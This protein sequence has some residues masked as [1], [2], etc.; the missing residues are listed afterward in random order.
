METLNI[1]IEY[2]VLFLVAFL[3]V[4]IAI[5]SILCVEIYK[6]AKALIEESKKKI[7]KEELMEISLDELLESEK[8]GAIRRIIAPDAVNPGPDD[9]LI[10]YDGVRKTYCRNITISKMPKI[11]RFANTFYDLFNE[12]DS[13]YSVFV[14][15][16][17]EQDMIHKLD[18][19]ITVLDSETMQAIGDMNRQRKLQEQLRETNAW[20]MEVESGKN[21]FFRTGFVFSLYAD[22]LEALT[23]KSDLFRNAALS[24][25]LEV[26]TC[27]FVQSEAYLAN[28]PMNRYSNFTSKVN[29]TDGIFYHYMDKYAASTIFNYT[30]CTFSHKD[31]IPIGHD[32]DTGAPVI[33]N[34]Y[35]PGYNGYTHCI[36]GKTGVG[37]SAFLKLASY[38]F[39]LMDYRFASLDVQPR[40]GTGDGEY[41]GICE[42]L[43]GLNFEL[44]SDSTN[45]LNI[46]EVMP[47]T[48]Y[49]KTG[50]GTG[51]EELTLELNAAIGQ[52]ANLIQIMIAGTRNADS[53]RDDVLMTSIIKTTIKKMFASF[54]IVDGKPETLFEKGR[55]V[56]NG[57]ERNYVEKK[58]PTISDF[59][60]LLLKDQKVE[61]DP[62][63]ESMRKIILLAMEDHV[64]DLYYTEDSL[65]FFTKEEYDELPLKANT[66]IHVYQDNDNAPVEEVR[67]LHGTRP[68]FDGQSTIR[69]SKDIKWIN[70][71]CSQLDDA[72]KEE[73]MS[74]GMNYI[75]ERII[76]GNSANRG[77]SSKVAVIFDEAHMVFKMKPARKLLD[78][79]V[80][81]AR[82]RNVAL[83]ICT[84]TLAEFSQ[85]PETEGI[86][87]NAAASFIFKQDNGD[88]EFLLSKLGLT[89]KQIDSILEQGGNLDQQ[90]S[91]DTEQSVLLEKAK[92]R[93]ECTL[94]VN[95]MAVSIKIDY[96]KKTEGPVVE[97]EASE[98]I[99]KIKRVS[100]ESYI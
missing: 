60:T 41:A 78:E 58:L 75:N 91:V 2:R 34:M 48:R 24:K 87:K 31:G 92:H 23:R 62:D 57:K 85:Y 11:V 35:A 93:G 39:S 7:T 37:K 21:K 44:K 8:G 89:E 10:I 46:F 27:V 3:L 16:I 90:G 72:A 28:A 30:S 40:E 43:N 59:V 64:R 42:Y 4:L 67:H 69:Y 80:R 50:I 63:K 96:R 79:V 38:R 86:R 32:R 81:T 76:K 54:G 19:H 56:V 84:Q 65:H 51:R 29:A 71:D 5:F 68:Y 66:S 20:A 6:K 9:Y 15:P 77:S 17:S 33:Y 97:T 94:V 88:R 22:S 73:A 26:T 14:E 45:C 55:S 74:V 70:I 53:M 98:I 18:K 99:K 49:I 52:A 25:G 100:T 13:T 47:T 12:P 82:K 95:K 83:A 61:K 36:V 1:I